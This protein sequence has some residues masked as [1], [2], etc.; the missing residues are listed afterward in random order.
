MNAFWRNDPLTTDEQKLL[1]LVLG[2]HAQSALRDNVSTMALKYAAA[3]SDKIEAGV[4][5]AI[6]ALGGKHAPV[7]KIAEFLAK[8]PFVMLG[9]AEDHVM[10]GRAIPGWG[11]SFFKG[12]PDPD[13]A[14]VATII[15]AWPDMAGKIDSVTDLLHS[16]GKH[17]F[18]NA[19]CYTA[20]AAI[21]V[22]MP[23]K[24]AP[25]LLLRGRLE[26][27]CSLALDQCK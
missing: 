20:A 19:G 17:V 18:P 7:T 22:G 12:R 11:N 15:D 1:D 3:G 2:A 6:S 8:T 4:V 13:W 23:I 26:V 5:A 21:I 9:I 27:W 16:H 10:E 14:Q 24:L 25:F